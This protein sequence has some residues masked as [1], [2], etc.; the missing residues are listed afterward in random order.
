MIT[1]KKGDE[2]KSYF[3]GKIVDKDNPLLEA[4]GTIDELQAVLELIK[5]NKKII[6]DLGRIMGELGCGIKFP[7][8]NFQFPIE[9]MEKEISSKDYKLTKFVKFKEKESLEL[10]WA[11]TVCRRAERRIVTLNKQQKIN[12]DILKYFNRLSDY[13]FIKSVE[14]I[15][16]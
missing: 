12:K 3:L 7:T 5:V 13:L 1:T 14:Q 15:K 9:K 11:R 10:N 6:D 4:V 2:G 16:K 8:S